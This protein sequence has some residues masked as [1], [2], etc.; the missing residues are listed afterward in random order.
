MF[1][2]DSIRILSTITCYK[3]RFASRGI[4]SPDKRKEN[5]VI[6]LIADKFRNKNVKFLELS[7]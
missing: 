3:L 4:Q 6:D 7:L 1:C 2:R 5:S